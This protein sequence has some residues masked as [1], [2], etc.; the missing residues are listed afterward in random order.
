M[1]RSDVN[2][3]GKYVRVKRPYSELK[4]AV[5]FLGTRYLFHPCLMK[6]LA[7]VLIGQKA[8]DEGRVISSGT[9]HE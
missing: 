2:R 9:V 5:A 3:K 6:E 4:P 1:C 7:K 8:V